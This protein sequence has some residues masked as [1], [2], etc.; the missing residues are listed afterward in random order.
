MGH[1]SLKGGDVIF[2][3]GMKRDV[4]KN[5]I[6]WCSKIQFRQQVKGGTK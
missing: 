6:S 1:V 2:L 5:I 3:F 4:E